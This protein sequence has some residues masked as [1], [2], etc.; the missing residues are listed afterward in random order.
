MTS[1]QLIPLV[2]LLCLAAAP[3]AGA[4]QEQFVAADT[5]PIKHPPDVQ[6]PPD[7]V[8]IEDTTPVLATPATAPKDGDLGSVTCFACPDGADS[9]RGAICMNGV[10]CAAE[11]LS[12]EQLK[13]N[14]PPVNPAVK[15]ALNKLEQARAEL[16]K[17][18]KSQSRTRALQYINTALTELKT[19]GLK[20]GCKNR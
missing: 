15:E 13:I 6:S 5:A 3:P 10:A 11:G 12:I 8:N 20:A 2:T 18:V 7:G 16:K 19:V 4:V 17:P 1:A 14:E 9:Y